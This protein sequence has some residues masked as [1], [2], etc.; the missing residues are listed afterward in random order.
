MVGPLVTVEVRGAEQLRLLG[1]KLRVAGTEGKVFRRELLASMRAA[2][3][4][5][6][7]AAK[8]AA[9]EELP[10]AG[11]LNEWVAGGRFAVRNRL[12][13]FN[14]G[15]RITATKGSHHLR[16]LDEGTAKHPVF[17]NRKVWAS[18]PVKAGW[19]SETLAAKK[20]QV[21]LAVLTAMHAI[22]R[23]IKE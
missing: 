20:P 18:N 13:G 14:A 4:P 2:A 15:V 17:G 9:I 7:Q 3:A 5:M 19:F 16:T 23:Q 8:E 21:Q 6:A 11:G 22:T 1:T 10:K 12:T